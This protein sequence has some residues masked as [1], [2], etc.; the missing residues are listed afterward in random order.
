MENAEI[1]IAGLQKQSFI[2]YPNGISCVIFLAGCNM[3]CHYCH[4]SQLFQL[5]ENK[6]PLAEA[7]SYIEK[8]KK[9]LDA[10]VI[11]GGEPTVN[12]NLT[13][14]IES[15]KK[16]GLKVKLDTN[17]TNFGTVK[18]LVDEKL[19]DFVAVDIKAPFAKYKDIAG[20]AGDAHEIMKTVEF[21]KNGAVNYMFRTTISPKLTENDIATM[22]ETIINGA[23]IWQLQQFNPNEYSN[24]FDTVLLPYPAEKIQNFAGIAKKYAQNIVVRGL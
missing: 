22:G 17:G 24:S 1:F 2:D 19:V 5:E 18:Q 14:I 9:M 23:K 4:N 15:I 8:N 13:K 21:L 20:Y 7:L 16:L 6:I 3:R 11:S 10:A 12:P